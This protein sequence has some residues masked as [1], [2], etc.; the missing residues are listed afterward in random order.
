[1]L[2]EAREHHLSPPEKNEELEEAEEEINSYSKKLEE[3][4]PN[5]NSPRKKVRE[6]QLRVLMQAFSL[7]FLA[8]WGDRS[9]IATVTLAASKNP[10]GIT[11]GGCAGH[12]LCTGLAVLGGQFLSNAVS[13]RDLLLTG[14][15]TFVFFGLHSILYG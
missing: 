14:G 10:Y 7:T 9:Q 12:A 5:S 2:Q 1:M 11:L 13:E 3:G 4:L 8:E 6:M 15:V